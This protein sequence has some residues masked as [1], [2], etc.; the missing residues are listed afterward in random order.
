[1]FDLC[2]SF[3]IQD[4]SEWAIL[5]R[6]CFWIP[7]QAILTISVCST[8]V[9]PFWGTA[10][11]DLRLTSELVIPVVGLDVADVEG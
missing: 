9:G 5:M 2:V 8:F 11:Q 3:E 4:S 1:M 10:C 6:K 7:S